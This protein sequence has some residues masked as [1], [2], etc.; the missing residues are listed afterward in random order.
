MMR[1]IKKVGFASTNTLE[2]TLVELNWPIVLSLFAL[3]FSVCASVV[4]WLLVRNVKRSERSRAPAI[5][6]LN[7]D[8]RALCVAAS[9]AG[10]RLIDVEHQ[11]R[12][13][14]LRQEQFEMKGSQSEHL[15]QAIALVKRG[16]G[17]E[18]LVATCGMGHGEA[19]L[20]HLLHRS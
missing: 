15:T 12:R 9:R 11:S 7:R 18:E 20:L 5:E 17:A 19:E 8:L 16:A 4:L 6:S 1:V 3:G 2:S 13:L 10:D 14:A